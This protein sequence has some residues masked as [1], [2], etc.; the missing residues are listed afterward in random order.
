LEAE[1]K[2]EYNDEKVAQAVAK[3]VSPDNFKTPEGLSI[4][5]T[6][7]ANKVITKIAH[8][9]KFSTFIATIDDL[10]LCVTT[11]ER[12]VEAANKLR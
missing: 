10:L 5:T 6:R 7:R 3:A 11:A 2:L 4:Q 9:G 8:T 1:I 12:T